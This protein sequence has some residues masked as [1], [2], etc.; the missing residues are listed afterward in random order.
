MENT[1]THPVDQLLNYGDC[2]ESSQWPD[3]LE[4]GIGD[5]HIPDL[6]RML[7][8]KALNSADSDSTKVWAPVHAWRVLGQL[9]AVEA[10]DAL[11]G[12]F[13]GIDRDDDWANEELPIVMGMMGPQVIKK[14]S[15]YLNDESNGEFSRIAAARSVSKIGKN[16]ED[17]RKDCVRILARQLEKYK[18]NGTSLNAFLISYLCDLKAVDAMDLIR[19][20]F[21]YDRVD[22]LV[23]GDLED[24]EIAMGLRDRRTS[25]RKRLNPF[26]GVG[27]HYVP[28]PKKKIGRNEPCPCGSGKKFKKCCYGKE[29]SSQDNKECFSRDDLNE[30]EEGLKSPAIYNELEGFSTREIIEKLKEMGIPF[31]QDSFLRDIL[32]HNSAQSLSEEWWE[33]YPVSAKGFEEDI[34]WFACMTLWHRLAPEVMFDEKLSDMIGRGYDLREEK[35]YAECCVL[36]LEVWGHLKARLDGIRSGEDADKGHLGAQSFYNWC[37]DFE[38]ELGNQVRTDRS[39]CEKA[40]NYFRDFCRLLPDSNSLIIQNM[41][42]AQADALV[43]SGDV[44]AAERVFKQVVERFPEDVW[45]YIRWGDIYAPGMGFDPEYHD[46]GKAEKIYSMALGRGIKKEN[47]ARSRIKNLKKI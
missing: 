23:M 37:Q 41:M 45:S 43:L 42:M 30:I 7:K 32:R 24:V 11:L 28:Q 19:K 1:Y 10:V 39:Y 17:V 15:D 44:E 36:W 46:I 22:C 2:R 27:N 9:K 16:E 34:P 26:G 20:T 25:E 6:I 8:D 14:L 5:E 47:E 18:K 40:I 33:K 12:M 21:A 13:K 3:Y 29:D 35:K 38:M 4:L 31:D